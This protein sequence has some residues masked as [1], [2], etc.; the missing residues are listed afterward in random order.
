[1]L[2]R[3]RT[4]LMMPRRSRATAL[5]PLLLATCS[6]C[7]TT[8]TSGGHGAGAGGATPSGAPGGQGGQ[9]GAGGAGGSSSS[10]T[11]P[12]IVIIV[13]DDQGW[14]DISAN[15]GEI[16]TPNIDRIAAEG[17]TLQHFYVQ[18]VCSPTRVGL[19]TGRYPIHYGL[20]R[21]VIRPWDDVGLPIESH[22]LPER[23]ADEGYAARGLIGKWHLG[24]S[25]Y[26]Q[27]HPLVH[28]F[29]SFY[30]TYLGAIHYFS[31]EREG[32]R[33][34]HRDDQPSADSGYVTDLI[35]TEAV[36][37]IEQHRQNP[38]LLVLPFT[39]PHTPLEAPQ[40]LIDQ[41][42]WIADPTRRTYAAMVASLDLN[43][44]RVLGAL[45]D[46]GVL[47][48]TIVWFF[49]DNGGVVSGGGDNGPLRGEKNTLYQGG[50]RSFSAV[51]Y[52]P[53]IDPA[54][55][56]AEPAAYVDVVPTLL[57]AIGAPRPSDVDGESLWS[58]LSTPPGPP[59]DRTLLFY[60]QRS[61]DEV[62][63]AAIDWP[64]KFLRR[65]QLSDG[66]VVRQVFD[67]AADP[68]ENQPLVGSPVEGPLEQTI[69]AFLAQNP[70]SVVDPAEPRP[71][72]FTPPPD[73]QMGP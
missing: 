21:G 65:T 13:A 34:W 61:G 48:S 42:Q 30:G 1:M 23:L 67:L 41:F 66:S 56:V 27:H 10:P 38:F 51:R 32:V 73:W 22:T 16:P 20:M 49:S 19:L 54:T 11:P 71:P 69:D 4:C 2:P 18:P 50:I 5:L 55:V 7:G 70:G 31:Q 46:E 36:S 45:A 6:A 29:T 40:D 47:D 25:S 37:F 72:G 28:G 24:H 9:G 62:Q 57:E 8:E 26:Q 39:A 58:H 33:A 53:A 15:D 63:A 64:H 44:G 35:A 59:L 43:V 14:G 17:A 52:P 60:N 68:Y 3:P 12:N